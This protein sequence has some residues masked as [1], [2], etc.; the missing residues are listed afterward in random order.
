[1]RVQVVDYNKEWKMMY[2]QEAKAIEYILGDL[3]VE[4]H[5]IGSTSVEGLKAKPIIDIMPVVKKI[6]EVDGFDLEFE[7]IG[8]ECMGEFGI[9]GRRYFRKG[10]DER[11]HQVHIFEES[12]VENIKRHLAVRDYLRVHDDVALEYGKLKETLALKYPNDI[13]AYCDGKDDFVK[14][15]ERD[16]LRWKEQNRKM[17]RPKAILFDAGDTLIEYIEA[18]PLEG[19]KALLEKAHNPD[20][21]TAEEIQTYAIEMGEAFNESREQTGIEYSMRSFQRFLYEMHSISFEL[22]PIQMENIFNQSAFKGMAMEG[23]LEFLD[24]LEKQ[25]I[26]K[27]ILSNSSFSEEAIREELRAY[28]IDDSRFEFVISTSEYGFRKPNKRIFEL[29]LKKLNLK[30]EEV[31]YIGNSF[32]YDVIGAQ[33][34]GIYPIWFNKQE[35]VEVYEPSK[36]LEI[37]TYKALIDRLE[38]RRFK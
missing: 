9:K 17:H 19:T 18:E 26:R 4:V 33:N 10:K 15:M 2:E 5:H 29:A 16:A 11:T 32:K 21:V 35:K 13:E 8:Y 1:M 31:W 30:S 25:G 24:Y 38:E 20:Q 22:D 6:E 37:K 36:V 28:D 34:A 7:K 14:Q 23:V 12:N 3:L 27:A